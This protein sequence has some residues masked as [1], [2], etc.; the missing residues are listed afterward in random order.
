MSVGTSSFE[1]NTQI[2]L[3]GKYFTLLRKFTE[4]RK[5]MWQLEDLHTKRVIEYSEGE[6][7]SYYRGGQLKFAT[8]RHTGGGVVSSK[9][10]FTGQQWEDAKVR[11]AYVH[12][13]LD[14]VSTREKIAPLV[15]HMWD[16]LRKPETRPGLS[17]VIR[18]K[19]IYLAAGKD[20]VSLIKQQHKRGNRKGRY[21]DEVASI[22]DT[23]ID[24]VYLKKEKKTI[25]DAVDRAKALVE[26]ENELRPAELHLPLP[27]RR[28]IKRK[29][30]AI[31]AFDRYAA[32]HGRNAAAR[33]FRSVLAHRTTAIPLERAEIDHTI[34]DLMVIDDDTGL[35]LG[36]PY[37]TACIDDYTRCLLG[38]YVGWEPPSY[39]T[40][41]RCL[42]NSFLPKPEL[43][44]QYPGVKNAWECYGVMRELVVDNGAEFHSV[45][46]E[47]ACYSLGIELHYSAR[48]TPWFKGKVERFL[49]TL[50]REVAHGTPGTTFSNIFE[51][52]EYDPAKHA[53]V[54][55]SVL[56]EIVRMWVVDVYH[57]RPHR[58]LNA[59][60]A[61]VWRTSIRSEDIL[62]P[63]DPTRLDAIMGRSVTRRLTHK[64]IELHGL[65]YNS[66]DLTQLRRKLSD[67]LDVEVRVDDMDL[68]HVIVLTPDMSEMFQVPA[69]AS[70]YA[71]GLTA[72]Q[73]RVCKRFAAQEGVKQDS[74]GWLEAKMAIANLIDAEFGNKKHRTRARMARFK[75]DSTP[76]RGAITTALAKPTAEQ[77]PIPTASPLPDAEPL[78]VADI[79]V[80]GDLR[81]QRKRFKP[82][83]RER[84][85]KFIEADWTD[86]LKD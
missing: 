73:H 39:L 65:L 80:F 14:V 11:R 20:I 46:L 53:I 58:T 71:S 8:S 56:Q 31:P 29:I 6:L 63:D 42:K 41:A 44:K 57:Q 1:A 18:W 40:V 66:P 74:T 22:V 17:S 72:W 64:G 69:L 45:S 2:E 35:P 54:R 50:N 16:K 61:A 77:V 33:R 78:T 9:R 49:G 24:T 47:N 21:P 82:I 79:P 59:P 19:S 4:N 62:L 5:E 86:G 30:D 27:T 43:S 28:Y 67:A 38:V 15:Q 25:Q 85:P 52:E 10:E 36:R 68:G 81:P 3:H 84:S 60:P 32:R 12:A 55:A 37:V 76:A 26:K 23:A 51:K 13:I 7:H 75:N 34:L 48:K 83:Y 70:Q